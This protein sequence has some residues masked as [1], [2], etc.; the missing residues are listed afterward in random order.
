MGVQSSLSQ[1]GKSMSS[2]TLTRVLFFGVVAVLL[3]FIASGCSSAHT[4]SAK[5]R[6]SAIGSNTQVQGD[7][8]TVEQ[9]LLA[10]LQTQVKD[11]PLQAT[12]HPVKT[13]EAAVQATWPGGSSSKIEAYAVKTFTLGVLH[14]KGPGSVRDKWL[15]GVVVY[16][17]SLGATPAGGA[18]VPGTSPSP[19]TTGSKS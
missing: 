14:T 13:V 17:N 2:K 18:A 15:Q 9:Q 19:A 4:G 10:N 16:A 5:A 11:H 6:A 8:N 1:G 7:L 12:H 3:A